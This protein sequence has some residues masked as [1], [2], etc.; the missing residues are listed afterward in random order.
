MPVSIDENFLGKFRQ[1]KQSFCMAPLNCKCSD[2]DFQMTLFPQY[3]FRKRSLSLAPQCRSKLI[4][5]NSFLQLFLHIVLF[6][7]LAMVVAIKRKSSWPAGSTILTKLWKFDV[8][9]N[10]QASNMLYP[11][12]LGN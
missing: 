11:V 2:N 1:H 9:K 6:P 12:M 5:S 7:I 8:N 10:E 3:V 4:R